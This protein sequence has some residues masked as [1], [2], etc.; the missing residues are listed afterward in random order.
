MKPYF[1]N[2]RRRMV[3]RN[4]NKLERF[5]NMKYWLNLL[6]PWEIAYLFLTASVETYSDSECYVKIYQ[7][8]YLMPEETNPE[9]SLGIPE[10]QILVDMQ[11]ESEEKEEYDGDDYYAYT[12]NVS[13]EWATF[14]IG[15]ED[16]IDVYPV[17][18]KALEEMKLQLP[19][20]Q[21]ED[22]ENLVDLVAYEAF[23]HL[24]DGS[25]DIRY[26]FRKRLKPFRDSELFKKI[27]KF[28][29]DPKIISLGRARDIGLI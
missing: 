28:E 6:S 12:S 21:K 18:G 10:D 27:E 8:E 2:Y 14:S 1:D 16:P 7:T 15:E 4:P 26:R 25:D 20:V 13:V 3:Q 17:E 23:A 5:K 11:I 19:Y 9:I 29:K 24:S 22:F